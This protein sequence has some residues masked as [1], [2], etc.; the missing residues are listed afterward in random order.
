MIYRYDKTLCCTRAQQHTLQVVK[1]LHSVNQVTHLGYE[2]Q[3]I[4]LFLLN[5]RTAWHSQS[6]LKEELSSIGE[7][8]SKGELTTRQ[9]LQAAEAAEEQKMGVV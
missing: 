1:N 4:Y 7:E 3:Q 9:N 5:G 8:L 2:L 6:F